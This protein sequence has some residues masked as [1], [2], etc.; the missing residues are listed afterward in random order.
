MSYETFRSFADLS[1]DFTMFFSGLAVG[2]VEER[3]A[4]AHS[5]TLAAAAASGGRA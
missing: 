4:D 5:A 3:R 1:S 2:N